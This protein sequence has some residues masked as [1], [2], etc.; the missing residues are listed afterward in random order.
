MGGREPW[1]AG[2][3]LPTPPQTTIQLITF[4]RAPSQVEGHGWL[5]CVSREGAS[6]GTGILPQPCSGLVPRGANLT[7][8]SLFL[9]SEMKI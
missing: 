2:S 3:W 8:L 9:H 7:S 5:L 6:G 1:P 4:P